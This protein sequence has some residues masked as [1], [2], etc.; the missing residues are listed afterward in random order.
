MALFMNNGMNAAVYVWNSRAETN[1][2]F[3]QNRITAGFT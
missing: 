3:N 2:L 1:L